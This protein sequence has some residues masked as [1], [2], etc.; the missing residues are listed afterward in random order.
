MTKVFTLYQLKTCKQMP[1]HNR[2]CH[3]DKL[4]YLNDKLNTNLSLITY[5]IK[6]FT[7]D[8][9]AKSFPVNNDKLHINIPLITYRI[10]KMKKL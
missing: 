8:L 3:Y 9:I 2:R 5:R 10:R 4:D 6:K 1:Y 7:F